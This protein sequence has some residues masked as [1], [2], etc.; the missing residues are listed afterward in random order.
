MKKYYSL[1]C[2]ILILLLSGCSMFYSR[3]A[4]EQ[5]HYEVKEKHNLTKTEVYS[6]AFEWMYKAVN[7]EV[8]VIKDKDEKPKK[9]IAAGYDYFDYGLIHFED[10]PNYYPYIITI[11]INEDNYVMEFD[12]PMTYQ[13]T[14]S[15]NKYSQ[16]KEIYTKLVVSFRKYLQ[17]NS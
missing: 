17:E 2:L 8:D 9:I 15:T 4:R 5:L 10:D 14:P 12:Y 1:C 3:I 7:P 16:V 13:Y 6:L 11:E